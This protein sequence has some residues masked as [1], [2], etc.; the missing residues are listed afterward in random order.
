MPPD[1]CAA[2]S[3]IELRFAQVEVVLGNIDRK[4]DE[5]LKRIAAG[6]TTFAVLQLKVALLE[7]SCAFLYKIVFGLAATVVLAVIGAV[8]KLVIQ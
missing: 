4:L 1:N 2:H 3:Q 7:T 6:D 8:L 5:V